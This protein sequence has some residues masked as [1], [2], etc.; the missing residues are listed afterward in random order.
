MELSA[1]QYCGPTLGRVTLK[2]G[3]PPKRVAIVHCVGSGTTN[4][5]SMFTACC[6]YSLKLAQLCT[7]MWVLKY[8]NLPDMRSFGKDYEE[9]YNRTR[10]KGSI[11]TTGMS[12][13]SRLRRTS[14]REVD[15]AFHGQPTKSKWIWSSYPQVSSPADAARWLTCSGSAAARMGSSSRSIPSWHP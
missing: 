12:E 10:A 13:V 15:E 9:F 11:S 8:M 7:N 3:Q 6:M 1:D 2:N 5:T 14:H 4:I